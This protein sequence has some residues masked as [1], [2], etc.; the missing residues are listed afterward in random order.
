[1]IFHI[2][3]IYLHFYSKY[4]YRINFNMIKNSVVK[5]VLTKKFIKMSCHNTASMG[6]RTNHI[7]LPCHVG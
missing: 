1:M 7:V 4:T 3:K 5:N 2:Y 6:Y